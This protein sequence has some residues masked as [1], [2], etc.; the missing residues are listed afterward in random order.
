MATRLFRLFLTGGLLASGVV[1][2][3][4]SHAQSNDVLIEPEL[5]RDVVKRKMLKLKTHTDDGV[6]AALT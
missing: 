6:E 5:K 1:F 4:L 3:T 2:S